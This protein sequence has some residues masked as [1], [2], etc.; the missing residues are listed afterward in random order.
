MIA[1]RYSNSIDSLSGNSLTNLICCV[2]SDVH[3]ITSTSAALQ[4]AAKARAIKTKVQPIAFKTPLKPVKTPTNFKTPS[5]TPL[6]T[7]GN[8]LWRTPLVPILRNKV[9]TP[10]GSSFALPQRVC[11]NEPANDLDESIFVSGSYKSG[12]SKNP[13]VDDIENRIQTAVMERVDLFLE[14]FKDK[15]AQSL[16]ANCSQHF[17]SSQSLLS[18]TDVE[19]QSKI[20]SRCI[21]LTHQLYAV[22][23]KRLIYTFPLL[24]SR[25]ETDVLNLTSA[26]DFSQNTDSRRRST[27]LAEK[28]KLQSNNHE[29][30]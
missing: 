11:I 3:S 9:V 6:K 28:S 14:G 4:F 2:K 5:K 25:S 23:I 17:T 24:D 20:L 21:L 27:R 19:N 15:L 10:G 29:T 7:P 13:E 16:L 8:T 12:G 1:I 18:E 26:L 30:R 22:F